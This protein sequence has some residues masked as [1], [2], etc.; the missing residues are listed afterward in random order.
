MSLG[1]R[2]HSPL[3]RATGSTA[4]NAIADG[5][6]RGIIAGALAGILAFLQVEFDLLSAEGVAALAP[7]IIF[8]A[9][10]LAGL[11][12]RFVAPKLRSVP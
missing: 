1:D 10:F 5:T 8:A 7:V 12:D 6:T 3:V 2:E 9:F 11:W 4:T